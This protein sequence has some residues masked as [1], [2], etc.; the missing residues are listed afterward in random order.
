MTGLLIPPDGRPTAWM[1]GL[2]G[3]GRP[4]VVHARVAS[5]VRRWRRPES[6][7]T[8]SSVA[9]KPVLRSANSALGSG[10]RRTTYG[11]IIGWAATAVAQPSGA[12]AERAY[13]DAV[14]HLKDGQCAEAVGGL[15]QAISVRG[16]QPALAEVR[17]KA[18][19]LLGKAAYCHHQAGDVAAA[20]A[21]RPAFMKAYAAQVEPVEAELTPD[22]RE[23]VRL[24]RDVLAACRAPVSPPPPCPV[25]AAPGPTAQIEQD[26]TLD[27]KPILGGIGGGL[28]LGGGLVFGLSAM[29]DEPSGGP[30][31][32]GFL[33]GGADHLQTAGFWLIGSAAVVGGVAGLLWLLE[34]P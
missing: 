29:V 32:Q 26:D 17:R 31:R 15:T 22:E 5:L 28:A 4:Q 16:T 11:L 1:L 7:V 8:P 19:I 18:T 10:V 20:C 9:T 13:L 33:E 12:E 34:A 25:C 6:R 14:K 21:I 24:Y 2:G 30:R 27:L 23:R 3:I